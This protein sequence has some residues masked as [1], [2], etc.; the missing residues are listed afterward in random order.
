[1]S[2]KYIELEDAINLILES[3]EPIEDVE[4][5]ELEEGLGRILSEDYYAPINNPP[6]DRSPLDGFAL[7]SMDT[8]LASKER[9]VKL[10][11]IDTVYAG[12]VSK[13]ILGEMDCIRIMTGA[14]M[15]EGSDC[16]IRLEDVVEE[17][18]GIL[19]DKELGRF[20]NYI[21][22]GEDIK[23]SSLLIERDTRLNFSHLG[24]LASMGEKSIV[25]K[26]RPRVALLGTGDE[27]VASGESLP[28]GKIYDSNTTMLGG[29]LRELGF[30]YDRIETR[31]DDPKLVANTILEHIKDYDLMI[32]TGGVSV[33]DKDIF[34]EVID[35][36]GGERLFWK[37]RIKPGTPVMYSLIEGRPLLSLSGNP[38]AALTNFELLGRPLL[39]RLGSDTSI[40][41][42]RVEGEM[43]MGFPKGSMKIRRFVRCIYNDG[44]VYLPS[45]EHSS[46]S[47]SSMVEC[48]G[49]I[50]MNKGYEKLEVGD[51]VEVVLL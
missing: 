28:E 19:V 17:G 49:L 11:K 43:K 2:L 26:R 41:T 34:H 23:K 5:V 29:R 16:V 37:V 12:G 33:G 13:K 14:K 50:D 10:S 21:F 25:V 8:K 42:R 4:E 31:E 22:E 3:L 30:S 18:E 44:E 48:N 1:M 32:T 27:L 46:G 6:F 20:D 47:L 35:I 36:I 45:G 51:R 38:F 39:A 24:V 40:N 9:L 7:R 15:P